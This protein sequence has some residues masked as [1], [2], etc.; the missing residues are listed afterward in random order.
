ME[1]M[2]SSY[3]YSVAAVVFVFVLTFSPYAHAETTG[4]GL[5]D[6]FTDAVQLWS[7]ALSSFD[8]LVH[9]IASALELHQTLAVEQVPQHPTLTPAP[10][11]STATGTV[12]YNPSVPTIYSIV[13]IAGTPGTSI[14]IT[15][16]GFTASNIV[17]FGESSIPNV[18]IASWYAVE[19]ADTLAGH[20]KCHSGINQSLAIAVPSDFISGKYNVSVE[21]A[22]GRSNV[23]T[24]TVVRTSN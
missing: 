4:A 20:L 18:P 10:V 5:N 14:A 6:P 3:G 1:R 11:Q 23:L 9:Q 2:P 19:C 13:P 21:N 8:S 17:L 7:A 16:H 22:S 15:G 12:E 24:F